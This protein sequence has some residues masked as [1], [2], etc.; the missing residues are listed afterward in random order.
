MFVGQAE[1]AI[2]FY[3]SLF[4]NSSVTKI[5]R[6][7]PE[8]PGA[9]G[10][11][12]QASFQLCGREF[13]AI[14][15]PTKHEFGFTPSLSMFFECETG[16]IDGLFEKLSEGGQ[17]LMP[18]DKYPGADKMGWVTDKFGVSWLLSVRTDQAEE[19]S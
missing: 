8:G 10:S 15:S 7:G 11:V 6:Y 19:K 13:V 14:D 4:E 12:K 17:V 5:L 16:Q 9:D 1:E 2:N 18:I 3:V